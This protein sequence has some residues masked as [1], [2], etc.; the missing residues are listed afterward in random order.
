MQPM[1]VVRAEATPPPDRPVTT[2]TAQM[3]GTVNQLTAYLALARHLG[4]HGSCAL[5]LVAFDGRRRYD[6]SFTDL[7]PE[8]L[9]GLPDVAPQWLPGRSRRQQ[10]DRSS[11]AVVRPTACCGVMAPS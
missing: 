9:L 1:G 3:R 11:K 10:D 2:A 6:L 4:D 7:D 8:T 5:A